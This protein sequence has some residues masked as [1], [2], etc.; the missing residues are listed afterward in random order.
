MLTARI[1]SSGAVW[2][3]QVGSRLR[4]FKVA[5]FSPKKTDGEIHNWRFPSM[6]VPQTGWVVM[7]NPWK[8]HWKWMI[9]GYPHSGTPQLQL[10]SC[11]MHCIEALLL[12]QKYQNRYGKCSRI[13]ARRLSNSNPSWPFRENVISQEAT[14]HKNWGNLKGDPLVKKKRYSQSIINL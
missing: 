3:Q 8:S 11:A 14:D 7:E 5:R 2:S 1:T 6:G 13:G 4:P 10:D 9:W 12:I